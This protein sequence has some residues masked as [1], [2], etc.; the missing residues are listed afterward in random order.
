[1]LHAMQLTS[2]DPRVNRILANGNNAPCLESH[3]QDLAHLPD[4]FQVVGPHILVLQVL[5]YQIQSK[6][7]ASE[8]GHL[9]VIRIIHLYQ[10]ISAS[11][12]TGQ[13]VVQKSEPR[14]RAN[15]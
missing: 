10:C 4:V 15:Q 11:A 7:T 14:Q 2:R 5:Q 3:W 8:P 9:F 1:M 13:I 6:V 12:C